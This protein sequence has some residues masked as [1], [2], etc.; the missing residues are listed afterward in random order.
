M[1]HIY[2]LLFLFLIIQL[3]A[4]TRKKIQIQQTKAEYNYF[5]NIQLGYLHPSGDISKLSSPSLS[6]LL[7]F[8]YKID[9]RFHV[10]GEFI[11]SNLGAEFKHDNFGYEQE[12]RFYQLGFVLSY[13]LFLQKN[14]NYRRYFQLSPK[15][16]LFLRL[17]YTYTYHAIVFKVIQQ[18]RSFWEEDDINFARSGFG[19]VLGISFFRIFDLGFGLPIGLDIRF[20][21]HFISTNPKKKFYYLYNQESDDFLRHEP[22]FPDKLD[23]NYWSLHI[24]IL[25]FNINFTDKT[26][27]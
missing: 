9:Y 16:G 20:D 24:G 21:Y 23:E 26:V 12:R 5:G 7:G 10:G 4:D 25:I 15:S 27:K 1:K 13:P 19:P 11:I 2:L 22:V 8:H 18:R 17:K 3:K 6:Y 14:L